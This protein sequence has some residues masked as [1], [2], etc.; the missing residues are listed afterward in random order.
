MNRL[1]RTSR[2]VNL[3][4]HAPQAGNERHES[5]LAMAGCRE[6]YFLSGLRLRIRDRSER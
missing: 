3:P 2:Y 6:P 1:R 4:H 5:F